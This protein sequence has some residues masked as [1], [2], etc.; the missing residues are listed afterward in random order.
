MMTNRMISGPLTGVEVVE[1]V[2]DE[3]VMQAPSFAEA[4]CV[5]SLVTLVRP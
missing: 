3:V 2:F 5:F 1:Q 4:W